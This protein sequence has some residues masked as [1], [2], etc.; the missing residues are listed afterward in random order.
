MALAI[1]PAKQGERRM[2]YYNGTKQEPF[3]LHRRTRR[4]AKGK[5]TSKADGSYDSKFLEY[6]K[7]KY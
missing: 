2:E 3:G 4:L 1:T 5:L 6:Y 7:I